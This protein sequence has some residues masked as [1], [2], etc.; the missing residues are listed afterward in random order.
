MNIGF[1]QRIAATLQTPLE[2]AGIKTLQVNVGYRCNMSCWHCHVNAGPARDEVMDKDTADAVLSALRENDIA[3]LDITGGAP[4]MSPQ[5]FRLVAGAKQA[6]RHVIV[7]SNLT[8]YFQK[9]YEYLPEFYCA[10]NIEISAS[11]PCYLESG[12]DQ[13]RGAGAFEKSIRALRI[14]NGLGYADGTGVRRLNLVYNPSGAFLAPDQRSLEADYR[15]ELATRYGIS[16]DHL[17]VFANM[18]IGR[19]RTWLERN[20]AYHE[21]M[22]KL[23]QAFNPMAVGGLMCRHLLSIG[24]DGKIHDCDFNQMLGLTV[25]GDHS[26]HIADFDYE[27]LKHREIRIG[28][29]CYGC[30][31]G[32][33]ST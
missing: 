23:E 2:S 22:D 18:P 1:H 25:Q 14:L 3:T 29:H 19:F 10:Q 21:Y 9:G 33:G 6:G 16:F 7:R 15:R 27:R 28:D 11:L 4:E 8:I 24:W 17:F 26:R 31:A 12:V 20:N 13:V 32:Q 5:F 30:A